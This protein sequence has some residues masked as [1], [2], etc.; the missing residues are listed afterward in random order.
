MTGVHPKDLPDLNT[1]Q[2]QLDDI[3]RRWGSR[4]RWRAGSTALPPTVLA[5]GEPTLIS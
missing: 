2:L 3:E 5:A 4:G 1:R